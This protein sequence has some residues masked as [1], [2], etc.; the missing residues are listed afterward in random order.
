MLTIQ[1]WF[2][3]VTKA[4]VLRNG[5]QDRCAYRV[6]RRIAIMDR[7]LGAHI[8]TLWRIGNGTRWIR[9]VNAAKLVMWGFIM[10]GEHLMRLVVCIFSCSLYTLFLRKLRLFGSFIRTKW[11]HTHV[12]RA[13]T[14]FPTHSRRTEAQDL[15]IPFGFDI[16]TSMPLSVN[17]LR[18]VKS[19]T[20][21]WWG[22]KTMK[23]LCD[24]NR[25]KAIDEFA[26]E[27]TDSQRHD[28]SPARMFVENQPLM[29][30]KKSD[31]NKWN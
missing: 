19:S 12:Q 25:Q 24:P 21:L 14:S 1:P 18:S 4:A 8:R 26:M 31:L 2:G 17:D 13:Q 10:I 11:T 16:W 28:L 30:V 15:R 22:F 9:S 3:R 7:H 5:V 6:K 27:G 23:V 20:W 29:I